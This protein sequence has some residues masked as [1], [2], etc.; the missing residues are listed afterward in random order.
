MAEVSRLKNVATQIVVPLINSAGRP[1]YHTGTLTNTSVTAYSYQ[2]GSGPTSRTIAGT[3]SQ[4]GSSGLW[5]LAFT[6]AEMNPGSGADDYMIVKINADEIDEQ[7]ILIRLIP[8]PVDL[9]QIGGQSI[10]GNN[11]TLKLKQLDIQNSAGDALIVKSTGSNGRGLVLAG[12]GSGVAAAIDGGASADAVAVNSGTCGDRSALVLNANDAGA[13]VKAQPGNGGYGLDV[14]SAS[15]SVAARLKG[16]SSGGSAVQINAP[17]SGGTRAVELDSAGDMVIRARNN[18]G[19]GVVDFKSSGG[20]DVIKLDGTG[21]GNVVNMVT[22]GAGQ[23]L[24]IVAGT[25]AVYLQ[26]DAGVQVVAGTA[27]SDNYALKLE[28]NDSGANVVEVTTPIGATG[29]VMV[30]SNPGGSGQGLSVSAGGDAIHAES[31]SNGH[32]FHGV[33]GHNTD[34]AGIRGSGRI[35]VAGAVTHGIV[36]IAGGD[37][38]SSVGG[39]GLRVVGYKPGN[40]ATFTK[41]ATG[42]D[43]DAD[44][45]DQLLVDTAAIIV[46]TTAILA[47]TADMQPKLGAPVDLGSGST[48]AD[49]AADMAGGSFNASTDSLE[50]ISD[51]VA[52]VD[53]K[54]DALPDAADTADAVWDEALSGHSGAGTAG[55]TLADVPDADANADAVWE[56]DITTHTGADKAGQ[57][58][59][60]DLTDAD[61]VDY[62]FERNVTGRHANQKP[63]SYEAGTGAHKVTV[64]V[65]QDVNFNTE[66]E[67]VV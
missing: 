19:Y 37:T 61:F 27:G 55:K 67:T 8:V 46:D 45:L 65:G 53:G 4:Q 58:L 23:G 43:I 66:T 25:R 63:S 40:G 7:T 29:S 1:A 17:G 56:E 14:L 35:E 36:G 16:G 32:G 44:Q 21:G 10:D 12:E 42:K 59:A 47:D 38:G 20:A 57:K 39:D 64:A 22:D 41:G 24:R 33:A 60:D 62:S 54:V 50:A 2:D 26:G 11:A 31:S 13:C 18:G 6:Q 28:T 30:L 9:R 5:A 3:P 49:N 52:T 34:N 51:A 48:L 15:V